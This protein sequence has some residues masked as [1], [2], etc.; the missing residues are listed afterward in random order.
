MHVPIRE[1]LLHSDACSIQE[2]PLPDASTHQAKVGENTESAGP[3]D[4]EKTPHPTRRLGKEQTE[5][6]AE[7]VRL[8]R[9]MR[10]PD[11]SESGES[12]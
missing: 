2:Q 6:S 10:A 12:D 1:Q 5:P 7:G 4:Q 9:N 3:T 11:R 8:A